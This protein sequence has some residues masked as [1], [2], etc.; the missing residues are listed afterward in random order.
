M[1]PVE[2]RSDG[3]SG[4]SSGAANGDNSQ[5]FSRV[6]A[7]SA[8][9]RENHAGGEWERNSGRGDQSPGAP[10]LEYFQ[11]RGYF[12]ISKLAV[13]ISRSGLTCESEREISADNRAG[14]GDGCILVPWIAVTAGENRDQYIRAAK[15]RQWG[16]IQ[17]REK[18]EPQGSQVS[19]YRG[20]AGSTRRPRSLEENVQQRQYINSARCF[21]SRLCIFPELPL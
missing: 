21:R 1:T 6:V 13:Q 12:T 10:F 7:G 4:I 11:E 16:A 8:C 5:I 20:E 18:E 3:D 14:R 15:C 19:E 9:C 17:D 2:I